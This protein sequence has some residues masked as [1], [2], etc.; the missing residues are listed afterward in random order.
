MGGHTVQVK[1]LRA[2]A[3]QTVVRPDTVGQAL[4]TLGQCSLQARTAVTVQHRRQHRQGQGIVVLGGHIQ[5]G[6]TWHLEGQSHIRLLGGRFELEAAQ[7]L[8]QRLLLRLAL[9]QRPCR[10]GAVIFFCQGLHLQRVNITGHHHDGIAGRV[11]LAVKIPGVL[12]SHG[13]QVAHPADDGAAVGR[14]R[15]GRGGEHFVQLRARVVVGAQAAFFLDHLQ[16]FGKFGVGPLVVGKSVSLKAHHGFKLVGWNLLK[17]AGVI[18]GGEGVFATT[19]SG[20]T[21]RKLTRSQAGRSF[22]QHVL[23]HMRYPT[24][25]VHLVHR[26]HPQPDHVHGRGGAAVGFDPECHAVGQSE[27]VH[28][29]RG[30]SACFAVRADRCL[31]GLRRLCR[32][33][34]GCG[35]QGDRHKDTQE[36]I[37]F[38]RMHDPSNPRHVQFL[39]KK[40][41]FRR[42]HIDP[43]DR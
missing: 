29:G 33:T 19:Q 12:R 2:T 7:A 26:T 41:P 31:R 20:D 40:I 6:Q 32:G 5:A 21:A 17:V 24:G 18:L 28:L 16:L 43:R 37:R 1:E 22:E 27:R 10:N 38:H 13:L 3:H 14:S 11:P 25:A 8:L 36:N 15:Q 35:R 39:Q 23:E 4:V 42:G 9:C 30:G 34:P